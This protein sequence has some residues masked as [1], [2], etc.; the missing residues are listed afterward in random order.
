M[1]DHDVL[2]FIFGAEAGAAIIVVALLCIMGFGKF[3][4]RKGKKCQNGR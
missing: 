4:D 2:M 3:I 1:S